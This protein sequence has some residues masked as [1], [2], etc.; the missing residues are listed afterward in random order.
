MAE[1]E[2]GQ[3]KERRTG[4]E[5]EPHRRGRK[6]EDYWRRK[7]SIGQRRAMLIKAIGHPLRRRILRQMADADRPLSP[8]QL[9]KALGMP[10]GMVVYHAT[11]LRLCGAVKPAGERQVRG[12]IEHFYETTIEDDPPIEALLEETREADEGDG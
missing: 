2:E 9:S 3:D 1:A 4:Q 10:L 7:R 5:G 12:A 11:V 6:P 8:V